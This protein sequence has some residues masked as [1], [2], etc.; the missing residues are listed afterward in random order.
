VNVSL[1]SAELEVYQGPTGGPAAAPEAAG[2]SPEPP[3]CAPPL[4]ALAATP[5]PAA[6][7]LEE[8]SDVGCVQPRL[9]VVELGQMEPE[10]PVLELKPE[11]E[12]PESRRPCRLVFSWRQSMPRLFLRKA[13]KTYFTYTYAEFFCLV[14]SMLYLFTY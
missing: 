3:V 6:L 1:I 11:A 7:T 5:P 9:P 8:S 12:L 2:S 14:F 4:L 10:L 13:V